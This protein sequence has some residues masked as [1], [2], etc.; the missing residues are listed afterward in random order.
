MIETPEIGI[1][2]GNFH[3]YYAFS[4]K[5]KPNGILWDTEHYPDYNEDNDEDW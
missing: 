5:L 4:A 1:I 2:C 3:G